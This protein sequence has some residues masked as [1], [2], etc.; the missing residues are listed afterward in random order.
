[1]RAAYFAGLWSMIIGFVLLALLCI[2][3][4]VLAC[5]GK[6]KKRFAVITVLFCIAFVIFMTFYWLVPSLK[7]YD[8]AKSGGY[9]EDDMTMIE[10]T[11]VR[12]KSGTET[13]S[14]PKFYIESKDEYIVLIGLNDDDVQPGKSYRIRYYPNIRISEVVYCIE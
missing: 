13:Y 3:I 5:F 12:G 7:D 6:L 4:T 11:V 9:M 14:H 8:L 1:M 2:L 10:F